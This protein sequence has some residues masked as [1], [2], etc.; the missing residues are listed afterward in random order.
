MNSM[1]NT[2]GRLHIPD[3][4]KSC[5]PERLKDNYLVREGFCPK[6]HSLMSSIK[7]N[8]F[9]GINLLVT[10]QKGERKCE[11]NLSPFAGTGD[12]I[13]LSG[14]PFFNNDI[15]KVFCPKCETELNVL[16]NCNCGA[17]I[18]I[19]YADKYLDWD[20]ALSFCSRVGCSKKNMLKSSKNIFLEFYSNHEF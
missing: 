1:F 4:I 11:V 3:W 5:K 19:I 16:F 13:I 20:Y 18:Y 9:N 12:Y 17:P 10:D 15:V 2:D 8:G 7:I 14:K 6:G